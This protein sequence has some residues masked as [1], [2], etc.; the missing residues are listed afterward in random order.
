[1]LTPVLTETTAECP[2]CGEV[3]CDRD[4]VYVEGDD[5]EVLE[6]DDGAMVCR[7]CAPDADDSDSTAHDTPP[8]EMP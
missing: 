7:D 3:A 8:S 5:A 6:V 1:M 2:I 4:L